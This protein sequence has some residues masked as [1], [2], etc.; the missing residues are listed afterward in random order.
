MFV[1]IDAG[2]T[3]THALALDGSGQVL[4]ESTS[5]GSSLVYRKTPQKIL[6][7]LRFVL[8]TCQKKT[9]TKIQALCFAMAGL[10]TP[11]DRQWIEEL[12]KK[13]QL[14]GKNIPYRLCNDIDIL[15]PAIGQR[16]GI[17][18]IGGTGCNFLA[19]SKKKHLKVGGMD[20]ILS[21]EGSSYDIGLQS[22]RAAL[23]SYDGRCKK[24]LLEKAVLDQ[25]GVENFLQLKDQLSKNCEK[26]KIAAFAPLVHRCALQ[27]DQ[28][29]Q[30]I[31]Q[32]AVEHYSQAIGALMR[33]VQFEGA[34]S[35]AFCGKLF[36]EN[37]LF[38]SV[39]QRILALQR[40]VSFHIVDKPALGAAYLAQDTYHQR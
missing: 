22:L 38:D 30:E 2:A 28:A 40:D 15:L 9:H 5:L 10:D 6:E 21:D 3:K 7:A 32:R 23:K 14:F 4:I 33:Q 17:A 31:L 39:C 20:Y 26:S 34:F 25:A 36:S 37:V 8:D 1:G 16:Q 18:V 27:G 24:S 35:I 19:L 29:S 13:E 12:F 11:Q